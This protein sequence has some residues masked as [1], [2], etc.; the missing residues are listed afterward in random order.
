MGQLATATGGRVIYGETPGDAYAHPRV[1]G[2][3]TRFEQHRFREEAL[4]LL[5]ISF[6][7]I[8]LM[9]QSIDKIT[10]DVRLQQ[11]VATVRDDTGKSG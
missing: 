9:Q 3:N 2:A 4:K 11:V 6:T 10:V 5:I 8:L 7:A 1:A